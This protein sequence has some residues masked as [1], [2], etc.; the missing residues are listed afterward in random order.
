MVKHQLCILKFSVQSRVP[1]PRNQDG[2]HRYN[3]LHGVEDMTEI[4]SLPWSLAEKAYAII[5][6]LPSALD[7]YIEVAEPTKTAMGLRISWPY[8]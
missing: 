5:S 1:A 3:L 2:C 8:I 6:I 7:K 4:S